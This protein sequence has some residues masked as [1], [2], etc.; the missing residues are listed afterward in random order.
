M[1]EIDQYIEQ[2]HREAF[3]I[4]HIFFSFSDLFL[5]GIILFITKFNIKYI[6]QL[7]F[8]IGIDIVIRI[9]KIFTYY[10]KNSYSKEIF[11]TT[12]TCC[13]FFLIISF[14]IVQCQI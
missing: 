3:N 5:I 7:L 14:L 12:L 10:T 6:K 4:V 2:N 9:I 1:D 13:Q 8:L 11:L